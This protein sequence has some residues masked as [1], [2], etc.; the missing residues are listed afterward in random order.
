[1]IIKTMRVIRR[2]APTWA[3]G[4]VDRGQ[5]IEDV[6]VE[7]WWLLVMPLYRRETILTSNA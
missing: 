1:M 4:Y 6:R 2:K 3:R 5:H 7:T